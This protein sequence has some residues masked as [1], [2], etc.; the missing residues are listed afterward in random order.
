MMDKY[1]GIFTK[2]AEIKDNVC[3]GVVNHLE[4]GN[5]Y[6]FR[7]RAVN[8][9]GQSEPSDSTKPHVAKARFRKSISLKFAPL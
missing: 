1:G 8:K 7:V 6:E 3:Q 2:A 5:R 4:E 9:A